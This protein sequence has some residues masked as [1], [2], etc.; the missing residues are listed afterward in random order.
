[1]KRI[2]TV[3][4]LS[5]LTLTGYAQSAKRIYVSGGL[6][7]V[8]D[9][10][11]TY[12]YSYPQNVEY[13]TRNGQFKIYQG[14]VELESLPPGKF[15][16]QS[17]NPYN[18]TSAT[19]AFDAFSATI[20][21][22][23]TGTSGGGVSVATYQNDR[24]ADIAATQAAQ[25][26]ASSAKAK[27][28][29]AKLA[30]DQAASAAATALTRANSVSAGV[31][32][33]NTNATSAQSA[34]T[35]AASAATTAQTT[36]DQA[37]TKANSV[38]AGVA[39]ATSSATAAQAVASSALSTAQ[40][41]STTAAS[42][43]A[44]ANTAATS[45]GSV[46]A[47]ANQA[48]SAATSATTA[49]ASADTKATQALS[50]V[51]SVTAG[52][53]S[54]SAAAN[55]AQSTANSA[56]TAA[57]SA[58]TAAAA[59]TTKANSVSTA[60]AA[61]NT[62]I[63]NLTLTGAD[64]YSQLTVYVKV[65][66]RAGIQAVLDSI[67]A[68][69]TVVLSSTY[70]IGDGAIYVNKPV[71]I[72]GFNGWL[73]G[74]TTNHVLMIL[75][76]PYIELDH[77]GFKSMD[78][79]SGYAMLL[80]NELKTCSHLRVHD[81]E[82]T[83]P[84]GLYNAFS[85]TPYSEFSSQGVL[86]EDIQVYNNYAH[87]LN[88]MF[89]EFT[90][91]S[92]NFALWGKGLTFINNRVVNTGLNS[93]DGMVFSYS[94]ECQDVVVANNS[95][96]GFTGYGGEMIGPNGW[97]ITNNTL[98]TTKTNPSG[99]G[100]VNGYNITDGNN[101][102]NNNPGHGA[103]RGSITGGSVNVTG[104]PFLARYA[105]NV[106]ITGGYFKGYEI[107]LQ[108][109]TR[110]NISNITYDSNGP[111]GIY[112]DGT[113]NSKFDNNV[114]ST[115]G[116]PDPK[117]QQYAFVN[118]ATGNTISGGTL[119]GAPANGVNIYPA[120]DPNNTW[121]N[122]YVQG[123]GY[124]NNNAFATQVTANTT[125]LVSVS[126]TANNA[127]AAASAPNEIYIDKGTAT[128]T[129][130]GSG[131]P[132]DPARPNTNVI[133]RKVYTDS[134][135]TLKQDALT[136]GPGLAYN[137][138]TKTLSS[139]ATGGGG[140]TVQDN[141]QSSRG[142]F[143][144]APGMYEGL[145][146]TRGML[147]D[148]FFPSNSQIMSRSVHFST[149]PITSLKIALANWYVKPGGGAPSET[150]TGATA[151]YTASV[152]YP[153][154]TYTRIT[155]AGGNTASIASLSTVISDYVTLPTPIPANTQFWIRIWGNSPNGLIFQA[156][157]P[158]GS[159]GGGFN[160]GNSSSPTADLTMTNGSIGSAD[161]SLSPL[162]II[163]WT[164]NASMFIPGDSRGLGINDN[165]SDPTGNYGNITKSLGQNYGYMQ[166]TASVE[167]LSGW[168][169]GSANQQSL[170]RYTTHVI[171]ALNYN[172]IWIGGKSLATCIA[173]TT[174][175]T[176]IGRA[177]NKKVYNITIGPRTTS[178]DSWAT[179]ANQSVQDAGVNAI[180]LSYNAWVRGGGNGQD[181][182]FDIA[183]AE[184]SARDS[185]KW[186]VNGSANYF[187]SD[188]IHESS[189]GNQAIRASG[190]IP[191]YLFLNR[192]YQFTT[193][194]RNALTGVSEGLE[195]YNLTTHAKEFYNGTQWKSITTN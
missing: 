68:Y 174:A 135:L 130:A 104:R 118:G 61:T 133:T 105:D 66:T 9:S 90:A 67:P 23:G 151:T 124:I 53:N 150:G 80:G 81:C 134:L 155:F 87:D 27:A 176:S 117:Y 45:V 162:A 193:T 143:N 63:D 140:T 78:T 16:N 38:S 114:I 94:C 123:V 74:G 43:L 4:V 19:A 103:T 153:A 106:S 99:G 181:G 52:V 17:G 84:V 185:G 141:S 29:S 39:S 51:S 115:A 11:G 59:A 144:G 128:N 8:A 119:I 109:S 180:R 145:V 65:K 57:S 160:A 20:P 25:D 15:L 73:N 89:Y 92:W 54:V 13:R 46:T 175:V 132:G 70:A 36:A 188:G 7:V 62:R 50:G 24:S 60:L 34:A 18:A 44:A 37:L 136:F 194:Q 55:A 22:S 190:V 107:S 148:D 168:L 129:M 41:A 35:S 170:L 169:A 182:Y 171:N 83:C 126:A 113:S 86:Y 26:V 32:T 5:L 112:I 69:S 97:S 47:T 14:S 156:T 147:P 33:A 184:E 189:A 10:A 120:N 77:I 31:A 101:T 58:T 95:G 163:G 93:N 96:E 79:G 131:T 179:V 178:T 173:N 152:E 42:A 108:N 138:T 72:T 3:L 12:R 192:P 187:T 172:D 75:A 76:S 98:R 56:I 165:V 142:S 82:F 127:L 21:I 137:A 195:I 111:S 186:K 177:L 6:V 167:A 2:L 157:N 164:N 116:A 191:S 30:A 71:R 100:V 146:A 40:S 149:Q 49:A 110:L 88:R 91:H 139:S 154:G 1:M 121:S 159:L 28:D 64:T 125:G 158:T 85:L 48:L 102:A 166:L 122:V 183:D 161:I